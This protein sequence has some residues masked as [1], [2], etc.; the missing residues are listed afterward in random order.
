[1]SSN[2]TCLSLDFP[3]FLPIIP[4]PENSSGIAGYALSYY[5]DALEDYF[6]IYDFLSCVFKSGAFAGRTRPKATFLLARAALL[7]VV[8]PLIEAVPVDFGATTPLA[9]MLILCGNMN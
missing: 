4:I 6:D 1:V 2:F 7:S 9:H 8:F 3:L 5:Y